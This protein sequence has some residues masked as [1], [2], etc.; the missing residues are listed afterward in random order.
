MSELN[1]HILLVMRWIQ[2]S[3]SVNRKELETSYNIAADA[4][5]GAADTATRDAYAAV[6]EAVDTA[7]ITT[8]V[9]FS[10]PVDYASY[11][12]RR[13]LAETKRHLNRY[14]ELTKEN[15]KLYEKQVKYLNIL[16]AKNG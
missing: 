12:A 14:F 11:A 16:G 7:R 8:K 9:T 2:N 3:D 6:T 5:N 15:R 4:A 1:P 10:A 13:W